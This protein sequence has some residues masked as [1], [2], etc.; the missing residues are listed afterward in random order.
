MSRINDL[1][2][3]A[4]DLADEALIAKQ[5]G[6]AQQAAS[7]TLQAFELERAAADLVRDDVNAEP[8]RSVL[9]RSAATLALECD[10]YGEAERLIAT[11]LA[12]NPPHEIA[13][14]LR[15]LRAQVQAHQQA[16]IGHHAP[17]MAVQPELVLLRQCEDAVA[18]IN[19]ALGWGLTRQDERAYVAGIMPHLKLS[20]SEQELE[21]TISN[22]HLDHE[23][24]R[25]LV[26]HNHR[27]HQD[28]WQELLQEIGFILRH[29]Q[30]EWRKNASVSIEDLGQIAAQ[31]LIQAIPDFHYRSRFT[32]WMYRVVV[33]SAT[34]SLRDL[35]AQ[36]RFAPTDSLDQHLDLQTTVANDETIVA[37]TE[38]NAL[39]ELIIDV[40]EE[41]P[42]V[43]LS[44]IFNLWAIK[45]QRLS[46]IGQ[47]MDLS[48]SRIS[49]LI[50]RIR[51]IVT[52]HPEIKAWRTQNINPDDVDDEQHKSDT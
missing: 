48:T 39:R 16:G 20:C 19:Q 21:R 32:T 26:N 42:D 2:E 30:L 36:K 27:A 5:H 49:I 9:Y 24:V 18:R 43:R 14:E 34:R 33:N 40:L 37:A 10:Q 8:T 41:Q 4:M 23:D 12:G 6:H 35:S 45:D 29:K 13:D 25:S 17:N 11:A 3:Q 52:Q 1:H 28:K 47:S 44:T 22:Y 50:D 31:G 38:Y 15:D 51:E 7:L 46:D